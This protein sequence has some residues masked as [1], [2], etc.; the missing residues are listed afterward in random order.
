[1]KRNNRKLFH[2]LLHVCNVVKKFSLLKM[3]IHSLEKLFLSIWSKDWLR[4][5]NE[6]ATKCKN[7]F[8]LNRKKIKEFGKKEKFKENFLCFW[9]ELLRNE[10]KWE[11]VEEKNRI[12]F[13]LD[14]FFFF[15]FFVVVASFWWFFC[16]VIMTD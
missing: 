11:M 1:M 16:F 15:L 12:T 6:D 13:R 14:S 2:L 4:D 9:T 10:P 8:F 5:N 3:L 7:N